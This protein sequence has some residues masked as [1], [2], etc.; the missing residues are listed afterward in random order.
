[1]KV[2]MQEML[3][4]LKE[5]LVS[6]STYIEMENKNGEFGINK[7]AENIIGGL[8]GIIF[9]CEFK[10]MN[11]PSQ[12][13]P[14]VDLA[15]EDKRIA[16]QITSENASRKILETVAGI[17]ERKLY[18]QYDMIYIYILTLLYNL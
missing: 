5:L 3:N 2:Q 7:L 16:V 13:Y 4:K 15:D 6:F 1:M 14:T 10:N 12:N 17:K 8:L 11:V 9:G 18:Q